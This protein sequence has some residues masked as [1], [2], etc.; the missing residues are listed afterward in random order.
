MKTKSTFIKWAPLLLLL[1]TFTTFYVAQLSNV[2]AQ[3][4]AFTYQGRLNGG[5]SP[6]NGS[7]DLTFSLFNVS[8]GGSPVAGPLTQAG[9]GVTNGLFTVLLDYGSGV[10]NGTAY[11]LEIGVR[12]NGA[13][14]FATLAPRQQLTPTPYAIYGETAGLANS[15]ANSTVSSSQLNT[16]APPT[17]GQVLQ[18]NGSALVW[19]NPANTFSA[20]SLAGNAGTTAGVNFVGTTDNQ[21]LEFH[22]NGQRAFRLEPTIT[23]PNVIGGYSGNV[24]DS[25]AQGATIGGGG[26]TGYTNHVSSTLGTVAGGS[27]NVIQGNANDATIAG[28]RQN[29]INYGGWGG[30]IGGGHGNAIQTNTQYST[31]S[32]GLSNTIGTNSSQSSIS[33]GQNNFISPNAGFSVIGGG[34]DNSSSVTVNSGSGYTTIGGGYGNTA[35]SSFGYTT[36]GG[37]YQN[38][39]GGTYATVAGGENNTAGG[40]DATVSGGFFNSASGTGAAVAGGVGNSA[41][42]AQS[43]AAGASAHANSGD[44]FVWGDGSAATY[45]NG[46]NTFNVLATG[47]IYFRASSVPLFPDDGAHDN[48]YGFGVNS[49]GFYGRTTSVSGIFVNL[50]GSIN[51]WTA[52]GTGVYVASGGSGWNSSSDRN[53]KENLVPVDTRQALERVTQMP[54]STWN[55]KTQD[56]SIR[57]LGPMAQDFHAAFAVGEDDK[58]INNLDEEGVALAAIQGLNQKVEEKE[59]EIQQLKESVVKLQALV[60][61]LAKSQAK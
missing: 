4:T 61:Q 59:A 38:T 16:L 15:V 10:F 31:I 26:V 58:H 11:W 2:Y 60:S 36:I 1:S 43:F 44:S 37:G 40:A 12:T 19:A 13:A 22:I 50:D 25:G 7:Y 34:Y 54:I 30:F 20:W 14:T 17:S 51:I 41:N 48:Y 28:G 42:G 45:D 21:P 55:Y 29:Q 27:G 47:G 3:G 5:G 18:F 46:T 33:G 39:A 52:F 8:T 9:V 32:G 49:N 24:V 23:V 6:A 57:H 56:K 53:V 35:V